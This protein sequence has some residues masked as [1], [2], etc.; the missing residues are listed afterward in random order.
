MNL[1]KRIIIFGIYILS[2][3]TTEG[4]ILWLFPYTGLGGLICWPTAIVFS[5]VFG[6]ILYKLT[7][8]PLK[9]WQ[10]GI[11]FLTILVSQ[12]YFQLLTTPQDF[13]GDV[14]SKISMAKNAFSNYEELEFHDFPNLTTS[15]R[16]AYIYKFKQKLPDTFISLTIDSLKNDHE[17]SNPRS[18]LIH[19]TNGLR[20][21][22]ENKILLNENDSA[23]IIIEY[24]NSD[25]LI[26]N[27]HRNFINIGSGGYN[28]RVISLY[29]HEDD[30]ELKS[31]I[32]VF[33][34]KII[35]WTK[36]EYR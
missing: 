1:Q 24:Y 17:S 19:N 12:A 29:I 32:E 36:K 31:G 4:F 7:K 33:L 25:T 16:V 5:L 30:F 3:L 27:M 6:F 26:Y 10:I 14:I 2:G 21:Y 15:E 34:Y 13:G 22:D 35:E 18:Y 23:T 20:V 11:T 9:I 28:N 8:R